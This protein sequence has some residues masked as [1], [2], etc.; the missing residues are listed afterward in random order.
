MNSLQVSWNECERYS[1]KY[2]DYYGE[3]TDAEAFIK[4]SAA[5]QNRLIKEEG[6][7]E[8]TD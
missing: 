6:V 5:G 2:Y 3:D 8:K 4:R 7:P 1:E